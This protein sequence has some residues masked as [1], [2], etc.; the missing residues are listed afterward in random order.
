MLADATI[1]ARVD[2]VRSQE[3]NASPETRSG[4][5]IKDSVV[6]TAFVVIALAWIV[7]E[8]RLGTSGYFLTS[9]VIGEGVYI[10]FRD[11][12]GLVNA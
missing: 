6:L 3:T 2:V 1:G 9:G 8:V 11:H 5:K 7:G 4:G 10:Q 12:V